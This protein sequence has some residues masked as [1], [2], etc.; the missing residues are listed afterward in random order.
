MAH[1]TKT[2]NEDAL[3]QVE[4]ELLVVHVVLADVTYQSYT[5][6]FLTVFIIKS[7]QR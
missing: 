5:F 7:N 1:L 6:E 4:K 2:I 3:G